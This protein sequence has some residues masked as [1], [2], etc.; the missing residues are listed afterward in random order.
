MAAALPLIALA[1]S[2][3][4]AVGSIQQGDASSQ[5]AQYNQAQQVKNA[6][7]TIAQGVED[8]RMQRISAAKQI[9]SMDA[10]YA[11]SG[12]TSDSGSV[13]D[14]LRQSASESERDTQKI[15]YGS[16]LKAQGYSSQAALYGS[17]S[18]FD[19]TGGILSA[20]GTLLKGASSYG[21][22]SGVGGGGSYMPSAAMQGGNAGFFGSDI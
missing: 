8:A 13:Q 4:S 22:Y 6:S 20:S 11:A 14:V 3:V 5:A 7:Q 1:G 18:S 17:Q 12:V 10:N 19:Q 16:Q 21:Y 2:A 15:L 9:G